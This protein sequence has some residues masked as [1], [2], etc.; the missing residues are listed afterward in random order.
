MS[1]FTVHA[2]LR[3]DD[4]ASSDPDRFVFVRDGFH[5]WAFIFG[6]VWLLFRRQWLALLIYIALAAVLHAALYL[7]AVPPASHGLLTFLMNLLVGLEASTIRR[8]TL[9]RSWTQLGVVAG[10]TQE[11]AERRFFDYWV[12][13]TARPALPQTPAAGTPPNPLPPTALRP[14]PGAPSPDVIGLFPEP[15]SRP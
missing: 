7:A 11:S 10:S 1:V 13:R 15:Q 6:P 8:W 3:L 9:R 4:S 12:A 5:F 14:P 2:P